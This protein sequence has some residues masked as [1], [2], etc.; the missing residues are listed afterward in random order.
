MA[1]NNIYFKNHQTDKIRKAPV[2]FSWTTFFFGFFPALFRSDWKW[3][4]IQIIAAFLTAGIS[5]FI[6]PFIYNKLYIKDL[7]NDGFKVK[8]IETGSVDQMSMK[9]GLPLELA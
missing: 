7:L 6:F 3:S 8:S 5:L 9:V 1:S 2:G 4:I